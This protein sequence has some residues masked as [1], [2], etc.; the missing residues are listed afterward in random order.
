MEKWIHELSIDADLSG[1]YQSYVD[2]KKKTHHDKVSNL[3]NI[4]LIGM[5]R[6]IYN[7][8]YIR[9]SEY[10]FWILMI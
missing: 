7:R 1:D 8:K 4:V 2:S 3:K 9:G 5:R 10:G 6:K